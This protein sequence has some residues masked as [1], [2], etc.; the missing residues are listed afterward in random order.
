MERSISSVIRSHFP[1]LALHHKLP[2]HQHKAA[3][4]IARCGRSEMG[5]HLERCPCA[6][7]EHI[8]WHSCKHRLCPRCANKARV[9]WLEHESARL[10]PCAH[11]HIIFTFPHELLGVWRYNRALMTDAMFNAVAHTLT[12]LLADPRYLGAVPG[13][14]LALH[15]WS[16]A[17]ALHP[18]IHALTTDGGLHDGQWRAPRRSHFLP[19]RVVKTLF[20]GK[21]LALLSELFACGRLKLPPD[22]SPERFRSLLNRLGRIKWHV[23]L[24]ERYT[25]GQGVLAYLARYLRGGPLRDSQLIAADD[26][27]IVMRY[28]PHDAPSTTLALAPEAWLLRYLEHA[29]ISG[30]HQLRRYGLYATASRTKRERARGQVPPPVVRAPHHVALYPLLVVCCPHCGEPLRFVCR[31]SPLRAPP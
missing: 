30:Q 13:I 10:L 5:G 15:T 31:I 20:R 1:A 11:H 28:Q 14:H 6:R 12:E 2:L 25:H 22:F 3:S 21:L 16:R 9:S 24:C 19:A 29:P 8:V 18:H 4:L 23:W 7:T 17:M 26:K 27:H